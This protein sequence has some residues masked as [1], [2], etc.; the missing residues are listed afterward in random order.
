MGQISRFYKPWHNSPYIFSRL[1][2]QRETSASQALKKDK[3]KSLHWDF[4][5][6]CVNDRRDFPARFSLSRAIS[7]NAE[8]VL[9]F[10]Q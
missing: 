5:V 3:R 7:M 1:R 2:I 10:P 9:G 8:S 6:L 4:W